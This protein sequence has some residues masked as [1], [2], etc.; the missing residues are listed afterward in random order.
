MAVQTIIKNTVNLDEPIKKQILTDVLGGSDN[1]AHRFEVELTRGGQAVSLSGAKVEGYFIRPGDITVKLTGG[2]SGNTAYVVLNEHCYVTPGRFSFAMKVQVG[3]VIHTVLLYEG[4][5]EATQGEGVLDEG[6]AIPSFTEW[7][8][9]IRQA[10]L[11]DNSD[12]T[13]PVNQR[14]VTTGWTTGYGI[15]RWRMLASAGSTSIDVTTDGLAITNT[16][17]SSIAYIQQNLDDALFNKMAGKAVTIAAC[18]SDGTICAGSKV[19][20]TGMELQVKFT[21]GDIR[22]RRPSGSPF[23]FRVVNTVKNST[24][25]VKWVALYEGSYTAETLPAYVPKGYAAELHECQR[26]YIR[27]QAASDAQFI[28]GCS[29]GNNVYASLHL[30]VAMRLASPTLS[31]ENIN[32]Y[33]Y[34]SGAAYTVTSFEVV[35]TATTGN[36]VALR[37]SHGNDNMSAG[38]PGAIRIMKGGYIALS[39]DL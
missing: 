31:Y 25:T 22:L 26:Y 18:L 30:P 38:A 23:M 11:L 36:F 39:A 5:V 8:Q 16:G 4:R 3:E 14:G 34:I 35:G 9:N 20:A 33:P 1:Q 2:V 10:N 21:G 37:A 12:F 32:I 29:N 7:M 28:P 17:S 24:I 27:F 13:N 6:Y 15:D 19:C